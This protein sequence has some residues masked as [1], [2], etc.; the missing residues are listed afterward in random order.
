MRRLLHTGAARAAL[1]LL[2]TTAASAE[3]G[4]G[5]FD[6]TLD[7]A[8]AAAREQK[9]LVLIDCWADWCTYCHQMDREVWTDEHLARSLSTD[10]VALRAEVDIFKGVG[11]DLQKRYDIDG[12]PIVLV[13]DPSDGAEIVRLAGYSPAE[14]VAA[15]IDRAWRELDPE[16]ADAVAGEDAASL[17]AAASRKKLAGDVEGAVQSASEV[18]TMDDLCLEDRADDA[19]L[20][21]AELLDK[22]GDDARADDLV[23]RAATV[24]SRADRAE[25]L[26]TVRARLRTRIAGEDAAGP[27]LDQKVALFPR[28]G[29]AL[30]EYV[31]WAEGAT[32]SPEERAVAEE[33]AEAAI[34]L[35]PDDTRPLALLAR[36]RLARGDRD[37]AMETLEQAI[38]LDP[39]DPEL[40][41]LRLQILIGRVQNGG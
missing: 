21:V 17:L 4:V 26:W 7:A 29:E 27:I 32:L 3:S 31:Q 36:L 25:E 38:A 19:A 1:L 14:R 33:R 18:V 8:L 37:G 10:V 30:V 12:L 5:W 40:R 24:C 16:R 39:H 34:Q 6:G 35:L 15:A 11:L 22:G 23:S 28:S 41:R 13:L 20:L 2:A 9:K